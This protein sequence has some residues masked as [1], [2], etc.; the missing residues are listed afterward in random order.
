MER[1]FNLPWRQWCPVLVVG[2]NR[3]DL[4][5]I[6][7]IFKLTLHNF[8]LTKVPVLIIIFGITTNILCF[9]LFTRA[10][11]FR[12]SSYVFYLR[13]LSLADSFC[14]FMELLQTLNEI[15]ALN[16]NFYIYPKTPLNL[17]IIRFAT[18]SFQLNSTWL[19]CVFSIQRCISITAPFLVRTFLS[20]TKTK[21]NFIFIFL[22][23]ITVQTTGLFLSE[24][25]STTT[26]HSDY[27]LNFYQYFNQALCK[28]VIPILVILPCN[29]IVFYRILQRRRM[30]KSGNFHR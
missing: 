28:I 27:L 4:E 23:A 17:K 9:Y 3:F 16:L 18:D 10:R 13:L 1:V 8:I 7:F 29:A 21:L 20:V 5:F 11:S 19:I 14:L 12:Q 25:Y 22:A 26:Q 24:C 6:F 30:I 15:L 2:Q